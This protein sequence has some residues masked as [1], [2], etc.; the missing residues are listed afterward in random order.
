MANL[1]VVILAAGLGKRMS[2]SIPKVLHSILGRPMLHYVVE[3]VK[4][5]R[6][7]NII[8]VVGNGATAV[9]DSL[10]GNDIDFVLQDRPLGTAHALMSARG[11]LSLKSPI[12]VLNGDCP[13]ITTKTLKRFLALHKRDRNTLS[14][15]SFINDSISGYGR[16]IREEP[17]SIARIIEDKHATSEERRRFK[18]LNGGIYLMEP[19]AFD[20]LRY[21]RRNESSGEYYLTD[22]V[23]VLSG[24]NLKVN[25]YPFPFEEVMGV[26]TRDDLY[27][28]SET[29]NG[30]IV[31]GLMKRGVTF[32]NPSTSIV[33]P[34]V[35]IGKDTVVYPNT[36]LEG[37]TSIG[38]GCIIYPGV[39]ICNSV[40]GD[41]VTIKDNTLIEE[42][43]VLENATIGPF[44]HIRPKSAIGRGVKIG[45]FVEIKKSHIDDGSKAQHLSYIGDSTVGKDVNIGAGTIT[46]NY[47][48]VKKYETIIED[49]V[50]IGSD[51]QLIAPV[52]IGKG[53][54][55]A[56]G[57]TVTRDVPPF[58]L[59]I[60]RVDQKNLKG[61]AK[62]RSK[63]K[64]G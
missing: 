33:H 36:Y 56:A 53:A 38:K 20:Y 62:K 60:S 55:V 6:A 21:I 1:S 32:I 47:D 3:A 7:D 18:E 22:I 58:A 12:L 27:R 5:L 46:C 64:R 31:S 14:I 13:L 45:N 25:A 63:V 44:A 59:A 43:R 54:Y 30:R 41:N 51:S 40:I 9:R 11:S 10:L 29:L 23:G 39:R 15:A 34:S 28:V 35:R 2:S 42:S 52:R 37:R 17:G 57:A 50:F 61:W 8:V 19:D 48:G 49:G 26:N 16:I 4:G 24:R